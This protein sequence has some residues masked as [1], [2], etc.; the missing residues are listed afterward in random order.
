MRSY[1]EIR[2]IVRW[3][4]E[5]SRGGKLRARIL[6]LLKEK[7]MNPN[8]LAKELGVNYRTVIHH[9]RILQEHELVEKLGGNNYG[10]PYA[11]TRLSEEIW[12]YIE[13]VVRRILG[14]KK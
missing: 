14:D 5:G 2:L 6:L 8:Q 12:E 10:A 4:L 3:L 7:P 13:E 11:L 1:R 9:L